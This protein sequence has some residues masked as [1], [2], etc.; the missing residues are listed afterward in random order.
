MKYRQLIFCLLLSP[1]LSFSQH[2]HPG[3]DKAEYAE[4][5]RVSAR[6]I[7]TATMGNY[8]VAAPGSFS[9]LFRSPITGFDNQWELWKDNTH[10]VAV[11]SLRGTTP[12]SISW[13]ENFYA[14]MVPAKGTLQLTDSTSF[15]YRLA[16][17]DRAAV[18][19]GWLVGLAS[20]APGIV[21]Q[22]DSCY[23]AGIRDFY[24]VGHSQ[25]GAIAYLLTSYLHYLSADGALPRDITFKT[26][27]SA[28]PKPGNLYYAYDYE[29][30]TTGGWAFNVVNTADWVPQTPVSVQTLDDFATTN[31]FVNA[32]GIIRKQAFPKNLVMRHVYN[33]LLKKPRQARDRYRKYLGT[34]AFRFAGNNMPGLQGTGLCQYHDV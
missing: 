6:Q 3:F 23:R 17:N 33:Q 34:L 7:D 16:D 1:V 31:P 2:I 25:G 11:I 12:N 13:L 15:T 30:I 8:A 24:I 10:P 18:H 4:L 29:H 27:C 19:A 14:A 5:L 21:H 32:K 22:T 20:M 9:R 28:A 26:Y